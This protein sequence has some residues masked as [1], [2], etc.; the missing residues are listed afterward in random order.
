MHTTGWDRDVD[1]RSRERREPTNS[2]IYSVCKH[3][4]KSGMSFTHNI[5]RCLESDDMSISTV[6]RKHV[7]S[8]RIVDK[9]QIFSR[10]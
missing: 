3:Y 5:D 4:F 6:K 8:V 9:W 10:V 2:A 7:D 1:R